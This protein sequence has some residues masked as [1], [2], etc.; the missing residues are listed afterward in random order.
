MRTKTK[1]EIV[2]RFREGVGSVP[3]EQGERNMNNNAFFLKGHFSH[4]ELINI[5]TRNLL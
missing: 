1:V 2:I 5:R 4:F 3:A